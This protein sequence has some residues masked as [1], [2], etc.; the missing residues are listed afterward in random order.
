[1]F[2]ISFTKILL[3]AAVVAAVWYGFKY[4]TRP[5]KDEAEDRRASKPKPGPSAGGASGG[6]R[7]VEDMVRCPVCGAYQARN[8]GP[9]ERRDCPARR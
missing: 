5:E 8:A 4:L 2:G 3:I 9:C 7:A 1:M 6:A